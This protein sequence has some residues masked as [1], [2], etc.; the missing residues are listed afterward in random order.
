MGKSGQSKELESWDVF[1]VDSDPE[2]REELKLVTRA[3]GYSACGFHDGRLAL[4]ELRKTIPGMV[5]VEL[6]LPGMDGFELCQSIRS[7]LCYDD[8]PIL[9]MSGISW[10]A[11]DLPTLVKCRFKARFLA[12]GSLAKEYLS[13]IEIAIGP[14]MK[15][16]RDTRVSH[17][18]DENRRVG[19]HAAAEAQ[20]KTREFE[21][22]V[23]KASSGPRRAIRVQQE[24]SVEFQNLTDFVTEYTH[25]ISNGGLFVKTEKLPL[26]DDVIQINLLI[27][28]QA[29]LKIKARV[30]HLVL[31]E[32]ARVTGGHAGFGVEFVDLS[33]EDRRS[34]AKLVEELSEKTSQ[35]AAREASPDRNWIVLIGLPRDPML[36]H[37]N[38]LRRNGIEVAEFQDIPSAERFITDCG[39]SVVVLAESLLMTLGAEEALSRLRRVSP[40]NV[41]QLIVQ[42]TTRDLSSLVEKGLCHALIDPTVTMAHLVN[43][44]GNRVGIRMRQSPRVAHRSPVHVTLPGSHF[45][46][47]MI[48][49]SC[50]G[51]LFSCSTELS[52]GTTVQLAFELPETPSIVCRATVVRAAREP[53]ASE[54]LVGAAFFKLGEETEQSIRQFVQANV[55]FREYFGWMKKV[56]FE[57][58]C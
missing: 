32:Q 51:M 18:V 7:E 25:N 10:G 57:S 55:N 4:E 41:E 37:C 2:T 50:G 56:Y 16:K 39:A 28:G 47:Q 53:E 8:L 52:V 35:D 30:V 44:V 3:C 46:A 43:E 14:P 12:K 29:K 27:P 1:I 15:L 54:S 19:V 24:Y 36:Q 34:L 45:R 21:R 26:Q 6:L 40:P 49:I 9:C 17:S 20:Q 33:K 48:N 22:E 11:V 58:P 13:A 42:S 23:A 38:F 5:V 31:P